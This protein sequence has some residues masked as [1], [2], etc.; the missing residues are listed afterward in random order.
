MFCF[1]FRLNCLDL[2][3]YCNFADLKKQ[4]IHPNLNFQR[5]KPNDKGFRVKVKQS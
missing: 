5:M 3:L 4:E 2:L 1:V